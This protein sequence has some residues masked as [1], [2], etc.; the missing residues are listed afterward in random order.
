[1]APRAPGAPLPIGVE[2]YRQ[3]GQ[4]AGL[5]LGG[6]GREREERGE[7]GSRGGHRVEQPRGAEHIWSSRAGCLEPLRFNRVSEPMAISY[8]D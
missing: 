8:N 1:M 6:A 3:G 5:R 4:F 7:D 2:R